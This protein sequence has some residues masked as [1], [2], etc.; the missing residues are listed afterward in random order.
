MGHP[1]PHT[2]SATDL[3]RLAAS[4]FPVDGDA[5]GRSPDYAAETAGALT[6]HGSLTPDAIRRLGSIFGRDL[7]H[8]WVPVVDALRSLDPDRYAAI[9]SAA[10]GGVGWGW[11]P[12]SDIVTAAIAIDAYHAARGTGEPPGTAAI[13]ALSAVFDMPA[14]VPEDVDDIPYSPSP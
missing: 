7:P 11:F 9:V 1:S 10:E 14:H 12:H 6:S 4:L 8:A 3:A 13:A 5:D 2:P